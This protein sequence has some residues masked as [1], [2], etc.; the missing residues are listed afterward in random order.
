[1]WVV[2]AVLPGTPAETGAGPWWS[3]AA[4]AAS[5][6]WALA[7]DGVVPESGFVVV[8][9]PTGLT[10]APWWS[11]GPGPAGSTLAAGATT[12]A[13]AATTA[14]ADSSGSTP[15]LAGIALLL[16]GLL[17]LAGWRR[18]RRRAR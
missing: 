6:G 3:D 18:A 4:P 1:M 15:D 16:G 7:S 2:Q 5:G 12:Q 11:A 17:V 13:P 10:G 14:V 9:P 8:D